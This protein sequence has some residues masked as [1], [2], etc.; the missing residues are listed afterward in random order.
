MLEKNI[1]FREMANDLLP[2]IIDYRRTI[3]A[4]PEISFKEYS[5]TDLIKAKLEEI[6]VEHYQITQ[7]GVIGLIGEKSANCVALRADIDA[8]PIQEETGLEFSSKNPGIMHACGHD[9]HT[10]MLLGAAEILKKNEKDL[11]GCVKLIFQPGEEMLPG[12]AKILIDK[13]VLKDP[14]PKAIFGQHIYPFANVGQ[15]CMASGPVMA[16][17]DEMYWSVLGK[18]SHAGQ[19]HAGNDPIVTAAQLIM[20]YQSMM[21]K[22]KNPLDAGVLT[23]ASINGGSTTNILPEIVKMK[24]TLRAYNETW[25]REMLE[26]IEVRSKLV[27]EM[28]GT[29]VE[30]NIINGYPAT[31]NDNTITEFAKKTASEILPVENIIDFEPKMWAEDFAYYLQEIPGTFWFLGVKPK[32]RMDMETLHNPKLN[33]DEEAMEYGMAMLAASAFNYLQEF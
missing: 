29:Q 4:N 7:T 33:P 9:M 30:L 23:V 12:G 24:G 16:S 22:F 10:S 32:E 27:G 15:I 21:N 17:T 28:Y 25:R 1:L 14:K 2:K 13:G 5:T 18:G 11:K 19:P 6:G 31:V 26:L 3:H 8:L 20:Y